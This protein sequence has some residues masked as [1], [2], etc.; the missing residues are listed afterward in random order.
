MGAL[1]VTSQLDTSG[2]TTI[3]AGIGQ[4]LKSEGKKMGYLRVGGT[5]RGLAD[6]AFMGETLGLTELPEKLQC[7]LGA[8]KT[9]CE[10]LT[11]GKDTIIIEGDWQSAQAIVEATGARVIVVAT[12]TDNKSPVNATDYKAFGEKLIGVVINKV[13]TNRLEAVSLQSKGI[14]IIGVIPEDRILLALTIGELANIAGGEILVGKDKSGELVSNFILGIIGLDRNP[15]YFGRKEAKAAI[16]RADRYDLQ[17][18]VL[19]TTTNCL[20]L[21][22]AGEISP[23]VLAMALAKKVA[24]IRAAGETTAVVEAFETALTVGRMAQSAK[25]AHLA[26]VMERWFDFSAP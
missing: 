24:V 21:T 20:V 3:A 13:P 8:L 11:K 1:L 14:K 12:Y 22:G 7:D 10:L 6:A 16:L 17:L 23:S 25:L 18:A 19:M 2:K 5:A 4:R 15:A 9:T 26:K